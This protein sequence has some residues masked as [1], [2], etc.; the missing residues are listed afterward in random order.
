MADSG[1]AGGGGGN[2]K[3]GEKEGKEMWGP[4]FFLADS[5]YAGG[6]VGPG[7]MMGV[8]DGG[9]KGTQRRVGERGMLI[10]DVVVVVRDVVVRATI[11]RNSG[12][13]I[14]ACSSFFSFVC[15]CVFLCG[16]VSPFL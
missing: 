16:R 5:Y 13:G 14:F 7:V 6:R 2:G 9:W 8:G 4:F 15:V 3:I 12:F 1:W 11:S 10:M